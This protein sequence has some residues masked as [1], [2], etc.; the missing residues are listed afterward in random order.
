M[1][2]IISLTKLKDSDLLVRTKAL[3]QRDHELTVEVIHHLREVDRRKL[4]CDLKYASLFEYA[5]RELGYCD[6]AAALRIKAMRAIRERP[7]LAEKMKTGA[8]SLSNVCQAENFFRDVQRAEPERVISPAEKTAVFEKLENKST[9]EG[10]KILLAM[11]PPEM[12]PREKLRQ[13]TADHTE[14]RFV[15]N[16]ELETEL[17]EVRALMGTRGATM[18][19]AELVAAMAKLSKAKLS[20]QKFG[21]RRVQNAAHGTQKPGSHSG[22]GVNT[23]YISQATKHT[24]WHRSEGKCVRCGSQRF[25]QYDHI[26]PHALGGDSRESN[27]QLL[28]QPCNQ[29]RNIQTFGAQAEPRRSR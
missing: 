28:C 13:V 22:A 4:Y 17:K 24:V 12:L 16:A 1:D 3:A 23:R 9:R 10:E 29:R 19:I 20:E 2:E 21:K 6:G 18:S 25:L 14:V 5:V 27:L 11:A 7:E 26:H 15:M 8:L